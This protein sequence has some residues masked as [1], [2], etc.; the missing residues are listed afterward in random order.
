MGMCHANDLYVLTLEELKIILEIDSTVKWNFKKYAITHVKNA[1]VFKSSIIE[2]AD[3][4][5]AL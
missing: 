2:V 3:V 1:S 5:W 4:H